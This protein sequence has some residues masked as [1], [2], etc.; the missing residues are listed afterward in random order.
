MADQIP[1]QKL[2]GLQD[3]I[4]ALG[5]LVADT[6]L[7]SAEIFRRQDRDAAFRLIAY[8]A[9]FDQIRLAV[10]S[11]TVALVAAE[12]KSHNDLRALASAIEIVTALKDI[13]DYARGIA[14]ITLLL[15]DSLPRERTDNLL[16]MAR[17]VQHLLHQALL[18]LARGD[19]A[20]TQD[21]AARRDEID[22]LYRQVAQE[23]LA[24][25]D[26]DDSQRTTYLVNIAHHLDRTAD[27]ARIIGEWASFTITGEMR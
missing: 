26:V 14:K 27:R 25:G 21:L 13:W 1:E 15:G 3:R 12:R 22:A 23:L 7:R 8:D 16:L 10:E 5:S 18:A 11:E 2:A 17:K 24:A 4:L 9:L 6:L 19:P 20:L